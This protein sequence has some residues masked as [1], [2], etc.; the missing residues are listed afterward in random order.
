[1]KTQ[2]IF[3]AMVVGTTNAISFASDRDEDSMQV[4]EWISEG[5]ILPLETLLAMHGSRL[6]G[7][8]LDLEVEQDDGRIIYE[9]ET[10]DDHGVV[11]EIEIDA[12]TGEWLKEEIED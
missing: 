3:L 6:G 1:M 9:I 4:R 8:L 7:R 11:R 2:L 12:A 5:R 10:I